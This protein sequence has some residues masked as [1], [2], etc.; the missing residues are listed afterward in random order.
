MNSFVGKVD[1][2]ASESQTNNGL[3]TVYH[4]TKTKSDTWISMNKNKKRTRVRQPTVSNTVEE[5]SAFKN[6]ANS[7]SITNMDRTRKQD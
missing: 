2:V 3:Q 4:I 6:Y 7:I 1:E 5:T